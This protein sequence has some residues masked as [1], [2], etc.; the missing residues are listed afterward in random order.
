VRLCTSIYV[1]N[2]GAVIASGAPSAVRDDPQVQAAY[3]GA[4]VG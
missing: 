1:L 3:L 2:F 4:T